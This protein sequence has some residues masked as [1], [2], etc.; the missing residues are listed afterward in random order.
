L[1]GINTY[2]MS[3]RRNDM[4]ASAQNRRPADMAGRPLFG[5]AQARARARELTGLVKE[6]LVE[7]ED[8]GLVNGAPKSILLKPG[9]EKLC[10]AF[11][12]AKKA[13]VL[14]RIEDWEGGFF[15]Y[16]VRVSLI[17]KAGG[18]LEAEGLGCCNT[19]EAR[20]AGPDVYSMG[21]AVLKIAEKRALVD[22]VL[23]ATSSS[24]LFT[25]DLE[26]FVPRTGS[27]DQSEKSSPARQPAGLAPGKLLALKG[28]LKMAGLSEAD[29]VKEWG[30]KALDEL[31]PGQLQP[32]LD[33]INSKRRAA[34]AGAGR[35]V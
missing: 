3:L 10:Q 27:K 20:L 32:V 33:W 28:T 16:L 26:D 9:A 17:G 24:A 5:P 12:L 25:Q 1:S 19:R 35:E 34:K 29:L 2:C 18:R 31:T 14:G 15:H 13:E 22:A 8:Y 4:T 6:Y 7:G 21:N 11:G 30:L 23:S